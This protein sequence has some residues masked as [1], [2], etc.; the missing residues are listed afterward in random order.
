MPCL[1][2]RQYIVKL[3]VIKMIEYIVRNIHIIAFKYVYS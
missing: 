3:R 1:K 2:D